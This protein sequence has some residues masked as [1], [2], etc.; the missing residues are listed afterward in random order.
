MVKIEFHWQLATSVYSACDVSQ[1]S[2]LIRLCCLVNL[3]NANAAE[4]ILC[5]VQCQQ[6]LSSGESRPDSAKQWQVGLESNYLHKSQWGPS[7]CFVNVY[8]SDSLHANFTCACNSKP[9]SNQISSTFVI[10]SFFNAMFQIPTVICREVNLLLSNSIYL[11]VNLLCLHHCSQRL[12]QTVI[13]S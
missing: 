9:L 8:A 5:F 10:M 12:F 2:L 13:S 3:F 4:G 7:S 6:V 11:F 1:L